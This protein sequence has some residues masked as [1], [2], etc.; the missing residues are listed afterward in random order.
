MEK[1]QQSAGVVLVVDDQIA[2]VELLT[3]LLQLNG[4]E[5][6]TATSGE[7][8]LAAIE[9]RQPDAV[10]LDV[11]MPGLS[12]LDVCRRIR[13]DADHSALPVVLVTSVDPDTERARGLAAGADDFL[14]KP[15]NSAELIARVRSLV[16]VKRLFDRTEAQSAELQRLNEHLQQIVA[17]KVAE[18]E[19]LSK[20]RR[21]VSPPVAGRDSTCW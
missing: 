19:R 11:V 15:V 10:L 5:V 9:R 21:F 13:A 20:L 4:Y 14:A 18:V 6:E 1:A 16:R 3:D 12:G 2:N 17:A 8:A 7:A